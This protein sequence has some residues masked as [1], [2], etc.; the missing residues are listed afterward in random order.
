MH[1]HVHCGNGEAKFWLEPE[2]QL[3][4][5]YRLSTAEL[6]QIE[7]IIRKHHNELRNAWK[8]HFND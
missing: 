5:N 2:I 8:Q 6:S 7:S 4:K 3:E 1:V